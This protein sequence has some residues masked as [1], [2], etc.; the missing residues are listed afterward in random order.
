MTPEQRQARID[1]LIA[2]VQR[3]QRKEI[4][5]MERLDW[6]CN[7]ALTRPSR[8]LTRYECVFEDR[9]PTRRTA[10]GYQL[11]PVPESCLDYFMV[12]DIMES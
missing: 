7:P 2:R 10:I 1:A 5:L 11:V 3:E 9:E 4:A 8:Y 12:K 6:W